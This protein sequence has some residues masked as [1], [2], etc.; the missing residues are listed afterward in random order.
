MH[1]TLFIDECHPKRL[2]HGARRAPSR[3]QRESELHSLH[4]LTTS[5]ALLTN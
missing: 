1:A 3:T 2:E 5:H 4:G